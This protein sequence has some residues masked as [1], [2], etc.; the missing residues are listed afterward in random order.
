M[1]EVCQCY[2]YRNLTPE[3]TQRSVGNTLFVFRLP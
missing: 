1:L 3:I 2:S